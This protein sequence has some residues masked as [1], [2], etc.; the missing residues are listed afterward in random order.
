MA[1]YA[2]P[3]YY[4]ARRVALL[5]GNDNY[6][7]HGYREIFRRYLVAAKESVPHPLHRVGS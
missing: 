7:L 6:V 3:A 2:L 1:L 5:R 4:R